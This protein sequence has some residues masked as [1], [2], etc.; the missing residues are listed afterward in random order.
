M[1]TT[2][3]SIKV[4]GMSC[5]SCSASVQTILEHTIG[6]LE[7]NVN[8]ATN[9]AAIKFDDEK[10]S[11]YEMKQSLRKAGFDLIIDNEYQQI[12]AL[13][14]KLLKKKLIVAVIFSVP[15][16]ILSM[17][18]MHASHVLHYL[19][20]ALTLPVI[21]YSGKSFYLNAWKKMRLFSA[22]MDTLVALSTGI[23][24]LYSSIN[25]FMP[26]IFYPASADVY[27]ESATVII[28]LILLGKFI[29]ERAKHNASS[30]IRKL[31]NLQPSVIRIIRKE[32]ELEVTINDVR[33]NDLAN[34]KPGDIIP[35]DGIIMSGTSTID[36][37]TITGEP[38]PN[39]KNVDDKVFAGTLN[40]NGVIQIMATTSGNNTILAQIIQQIEA[41]Q[42]SKP[43]IQKL[44]DKIASWFVPIVLLLALITFFCWLFF[45]PNPA[46]HYAFHTA[47]SVLIIACPCALGLAT[48]TAL[49]AGIG[50]GAEN[51]ILI[52]DAQ[53]LELANKINI[54]AL[55][56]TGTLTT[57]KPTVSSFHIFQTNNAEF[58][59]NIIFAIESKLSHPIASAISSYLQDKKT[60]S[61]ELLEIEN[62][63]GKGAKAFYLDVL[64]IIGNRKLMSDYNIQL[65]EISVSTFDTEVFVA[66][67]NQ[68]LTTITVGDILKADTINAIH[69]IKQLGIEIVMITGDSE[70]SASHFAKL[71]GI[72]RYYA[73]VLPTEKQQI[74][75]QMQ[76]G[77]K[78]V[79]MVGDGINDASAMSQADISI[80]MASGADIAKESAGIT[81]LRSS[82]T[83]VY[84]A[85][86][87]SK[88]MLVA[89]KQNLFWAF[90]YN[91]IAIPIA[92]GV[93][94]PFTGHLL[95]PMI[96]GAAM[97][98][99]SI[100]VISNSLRIKLKQ[101]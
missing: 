87:L 7:A 62:I 17:F 8:L 25:T 3:I 66:A 35:V 54:I 63:P 1:A 41:S 79:A 92:A 43:P 30:A 20:F 22:N 80:A 33:K 84:K 90:I 97:A 14:I 49:T 78:I 45:G 10:V 89:I 11:I 28:T 51:G 86:K 16:F 83:D 42:F 5:A 44:V 93:L 65:P 75:A 4:S 61:I 36:E 94:Y 31:I 9:T 21:G 12:E 81:I 71:I 2:K 53:S 99:S 70:N 27:Y 72:N 34:V 56:K 55:D 64:Y 19:L 76:N 59:N 98:F 50:K 32:K 47:I 82:I 23:A 85:L 38:I 29:E 69:K 48:P 91:I 18:F 52:K 24:F 74:I 40:Q 88:Y 100:S 73:E 77:G 37:S 58:I 39:E 67:D 60:M 68:L 26:Q 96:A 101:L 6:V 13:R 15:I 46:I 57:G 95:S